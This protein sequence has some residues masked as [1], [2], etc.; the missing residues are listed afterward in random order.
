MS[1]TSIAN[2]IMGMSSQ[3]AEAEDH[4]INDDLRNFFHGPLEFSRRDL[5][6]VIIQV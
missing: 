1:Q 3:I 5:V 2:V 6:A 4:V